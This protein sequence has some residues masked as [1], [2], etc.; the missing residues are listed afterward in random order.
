MKR[1]IAICEHLEVPILCKKIDKKVLFYIFFLPVIKL[2]KFGTFH[3]YKL[4]SSISTNE[5]IACLGAQPPC[6]WVGIIINEININK[7]RTSNLL[8]CISVA[9]DTA[10]Y[11]GLV[12]VYMLQRIC[13]TS[14]FT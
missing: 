13:V 4:Q 8:G 10:Q 7:Y 14:D 2:V 3:F 9:F 11:R 6:V 5:F 1:F 12:I